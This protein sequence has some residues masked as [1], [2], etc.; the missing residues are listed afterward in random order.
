M[1]PEFPI[2]AEYSPERARHPA[3]T[4]VDIASEQAAVTAAYG[5][6]VL[7]DVNGDCMRLAVFEGDYRW[8]R[9]PDSDELFLVVAGKLQIDPAGADTLELAEWQSLVI[10]RG[11]VHRTRAIGRTVNVTFEKRSAR[12]VFVE[13]PPNASCG[14]DA[15][16]KP[17]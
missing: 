12:T 15:S 7:F 4:V 11:T 6:Q 17:A 14:A 2:A 1:K 16:R 10:P 13:P 9:H 3:L 8:H 5:D